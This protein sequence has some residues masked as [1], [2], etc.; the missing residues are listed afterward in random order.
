MDISKYVEFKSQKKL[1]AVIER[2]KTYELSE[3]I[4]FLFMNFKKNQSYLLL[5]KHSFGV[6]PVLLDQFWMHI[7]L[8]MFVFY[9]MRFCNGILRS[10]TF[11]SQNKWIECHQANTFM[12]IVYKIHF[13]HQTKSMCMC[14]Y[15]VY[16][17]CIDSIQLKSLI[18]CS[19]ILFSNIS[20]EI[21]INIR[22]IK[23]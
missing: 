16:F 3:E 12:Q 22:P 10:K 14:I 15:Y 18:L 2:K 5:S 20:F 23:S 13:Q 4:K 1:A 8:S 17:K 9:G 6:T 19:I 21:I 11:K 7:N